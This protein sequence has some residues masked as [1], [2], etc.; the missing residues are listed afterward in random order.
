MRGRITGELYIPLF[1]LLY[2]YDKN[3]D[4]L[5]FLAPYHADAQK[6]GTGLSS[7]K[8]VSLDYNGP[9][10]KWLHPTVFFMCLSNGHDLVNPYNTVVIVNGIKCGIASSDRGSVYIDTFFKR[11]FLFVATGSWRGILFKSRQSAV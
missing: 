10:R 1:R 11:E 5:V 9:H 4:I 2:R 3:K 7:F 6:C 8:S